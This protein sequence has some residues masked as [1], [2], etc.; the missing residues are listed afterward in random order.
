MVTESRTES[1]NLLK[2][3]LDRWR[4][5][6]L[7]LEVLRTDAERLRSL[8]P[9]GPLRQLCVVLGSL[10]QSA[11]ENR[12]PL[13]VE[14]L[15]ETILALETADET[16]AITALAALEE[17][18]AEA[19]FFE[20]PALAPTN[21]V[22]LWPVRVLTVDDSS[23]VRSALRR[24]FTDSGAILEETADGTAALEHLEKLAR[25]DLILLDIMLPDISG[26]EVLERFRERNAEIV[27]VM[28]TGETEIETAISA[29]R[30]GADGYMQKKDLPIDGDRKE[31]FAQLEQ[32][33][34]YRAGETAKRELEHLKSDLYAMVTH[35]LRNPANIIQLSLE[36]LLENQADKLVPEVA[37]SVR[38][39]AEAAA[40]MLRLVTEYLDY[41]KIDAG[42]LT[43]ERSDFDLVAAVR[44]CVDLS[45]VIAESKSQTLGFEAPIRLPMYADA[46]RLK[47]VVDNLVSNAIKYTPSGG[48]VR[49]S[50]EHINSLVRL[51]VQDTGPGIPTEHLGQLFEKYR[52][53]PGESRRTKG[54][55]LGLV[56]VRSII[57]AHHGKVWAESG[58]DGMGSSFV[59]EIPI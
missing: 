48:S 18:E 2:E 17:L 13:K 50:L 19:A 57:E 26:L 58:G 12:F 51:R 35:D 54:T 20:P 15:S 24:V 11:G 5:E 33:R 16:L 14:S 29:V 6:P 21:I 36:E 34:R 1:L 28:L 56:I 25:F 39:A 30:R 32:A 3:C 41:A 42:Y 27:I 37:Q 49:V 43:L 55:G 38:L 40:K 4:T 31:F 22:P 53:L 7:S 47:Q 10:A 9:E 59:F 45:K 52:R 23:L 46:E 8:M 44:G